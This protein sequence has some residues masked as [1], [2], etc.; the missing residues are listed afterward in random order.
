[1]AE[2]YNFL[3]KENGTG[4]M[5]CAFLIQIARLVSGDQIA[6]P[7]VS[8]VP[9]G[10]NA[11]ERL[12]PVTVLQATVGHPVPHVSPHIGLCHAKAVKL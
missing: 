1:M 12:E 8:P 6:S 2:I 9:M 7:P 10:E 3:E 4:D 11:T 5:S